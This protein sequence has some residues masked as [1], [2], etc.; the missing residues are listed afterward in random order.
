M[1]MMYLSVRRT[2]LWTGQLKPPKG[3]RSDDFLAVLVT[4]VTKRMGISQN[5]IF[6]LAS[7]THAPDLSQM[8]PS[9]DSPEIYTPS[10]GG[11][12]TCSARSYSVTS[13]STR[14]PSNAQPSLR[15]LRVTSCWT[16]VKKPSSIRPAREPVGLRSSFAGDPPSQL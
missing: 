3:P 8:A 11:A 1:K 4:A 15:C 6:G 7:A 12:R 2:Y 9:N 14:T 13:E 5:N 10:G 16:A